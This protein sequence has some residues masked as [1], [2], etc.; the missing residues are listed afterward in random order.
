M[1]QKKLHRPS[2]ESSQPAKL[3][4]QPAMAQFSESTIIGPSFF[5]IAAWTS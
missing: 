1:I 4:G 3:T 2:A 5:V